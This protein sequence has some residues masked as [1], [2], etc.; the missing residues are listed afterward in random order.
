MIAEIDVGEDG[1]TGTIDFLEFTSLMTRP[2]ANE[3][4]GLDKEL[5]SIFEDLK[6][7]RKKLLEKEDL[8]NG[9]KKCG[10]QFHPRFIEEMIRE[11]DT[12]NQGGVALQDL[13]KVMGPAEKE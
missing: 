12:K 13:L 11:V 10:L 7:P 3:L 2:Y 8:L 5:K 9:F 4:E 1:G 6:K